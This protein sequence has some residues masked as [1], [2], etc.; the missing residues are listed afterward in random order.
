MLLYTKWFELQHSE[1][2][3]E[4]GVSELLLV[5]PPKDYTSGTPLFLYYP[6]INF[7]DSRMH[8]NDIIHP[9]TMKVCLNIR[10]AHPGIA[11]IPCI[12]I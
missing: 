10:L 5:Y 2:V 1:R 4:F 7:F 9:L 8:V 6:K 3:F 11:H 12:K